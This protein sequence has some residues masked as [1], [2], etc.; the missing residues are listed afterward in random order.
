V[1]VLF[2]QSGNAVL[3]HRTP[4]N[5]ATLATFKVLGD[6]ASPSFSDGY[7]LLRTDPE[8]Q[9]ERL[10]LA[11]HLDRPPDKTLQFIGEM[12]MSGM[13]MSGMDMGGMDMGGIEL[14]PTDM[15]DGRMD[16]TKAMPGPDMQQMQHQ[17]DPAGMHGHQVGGG[18]AHSM[19]QPE[20]SDGIEWEDTMPEMNIMSNL[21]NMAWR[22]VDTETGAAN[23]EISWTLHVGDRLK[24]RLD[25]SAGSDH[26]MHHPFHVHGAGRFLVLDR[27]GVPEPNLVWKDTVLVR[28]G[29]IVNILFDVT[30]PGRWMAHCHI[31]EH[32]ESGMMFSFDVIDTAVAGVSAP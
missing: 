16:N 12:D 29:E 9:A 3:E 23:E 21:S 7:R 18:S 22:I 10:G 15:N 20:T 28:A 5:A 1:D 30:N 31:A 17:S 11:A 26:Q 19:H 32:I 2:D 25:N 8:L 24:I 4:H 13:D 6:A 14:S 27:G